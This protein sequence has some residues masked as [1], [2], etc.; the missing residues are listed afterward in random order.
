LEVILNRLAG[1]IEKSVKLRGKVKSAMFYPAAI[2]LVA[3]V[4][5]SFILVFVVPKLAAMFKQGGQELPALTVWVIN[6]S[7]FIQSYWYF[8][9]ALLVGIPMGL[10]MFYDTPDG[11]KVIDTIVLEIPILGDL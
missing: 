9:V 7:D 1:Y 5:I 11:Q 6:A 4:V 10:R 2:I 8:M 3:I